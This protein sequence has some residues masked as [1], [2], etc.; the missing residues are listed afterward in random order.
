MPIIIYYLF[1]IDYLLDLIKGKTQVE[2]RI[3]ENQHYWHTLST[4]YKDSYLASIF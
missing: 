3:I 2:Y 4:A 1:I